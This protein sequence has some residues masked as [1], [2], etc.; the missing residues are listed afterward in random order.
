MKG[1]LFNLVEGGSVWISL[2]AVASVYA[3]D[4]QSPATILTLTGVAYV[5][6]TALQDTLMALAEGYYAGEPRVK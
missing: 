1:M 5:V 6:T 2:P 4:D 3:A